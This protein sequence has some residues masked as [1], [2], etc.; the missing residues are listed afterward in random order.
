[1]LLIV[2]AGFKDSLELAT[3]PAVCSTIPGCIQSVDKMWRIIV[4]FGAVP[5]CIALYFRLTIPETPR[6][7][8]DVDQD[9]QKAEADVEA[10]Q[11]G[12]WGDGQ[13]T[14]D[15]VSRAQD[16]VAARAELTIPKASWADFRRHYNQWKNLKVLLGCALSWFFLDVA[17]YGLGL[18]NAI[19]LNAIGWSGGANVYEIYY[20]TAVGNLILVLAGAVPGYW[21]SACIIDTVGRKPVQ[22][23]GFFALTVLFCVIG[24][25]FW[26]LSGPSL[27]ALYTLAQF[28][29]NAG[30]NSTTFVVPGECFPTRYRSTSHGISAASGKI[31]AIIAQVVFG[32]LK[33]IGANPTLAKT[34]PRWTNPFI[35]HIMQIFA[36]F[37]LLGMFSSFLIPE[38]ARKTLEE[39]AGED[40][41][42]F[43]A[44]SSPAMSGT[45]E[46][47]AE[48]GRA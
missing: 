33:T 29:F 31:G 12:Q 40:M 44:P 15:E 1:M 4:G 23:F 42:A 28:F 17:F 47:N 10:Y 27:M 32:P 43:S 9:V 14:V 37:M 13:M 5:G 6:Y 7:T 45:P 11:T 48:E 41:D 24:F 39:L 26:N 2:T 25:D 19:I 3:K 35:P 22:I 34:D 20:N 36:L 21:V 16:K 30:P 38:T 46:K 8:F 18:N